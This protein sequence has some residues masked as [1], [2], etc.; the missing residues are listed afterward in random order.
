MPCQYHPISTNSVGSYD[1]ILTDTLRL[2]T[3]IS[4]VRRSVNYQVFS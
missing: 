1:F 3:K 4:P 2:N